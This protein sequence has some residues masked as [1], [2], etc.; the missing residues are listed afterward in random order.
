MLQPRGIQSWWCATSKGVLQPQVIILSKIYRHYLEPFKVFVFKTPKARAHELKSSLVL[1]NNSLVLGM[2]QI[3]LL[4][5]YVQLKDVI[6]PI[7][8]ELECS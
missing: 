5:L 2:V 4:S 1:F 6:F 3:I 8:L 7:L